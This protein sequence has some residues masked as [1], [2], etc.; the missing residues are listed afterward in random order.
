V[1]KN[2]DTT[3]QRAARITGAIFR[4]GEGRIGIVSSRLH[5]Y[6]VGFR[7]AHAELIHDDQLDMVT[8]SLY[9]RHGQS[10]DANIEK[11]HRRP[12]DEAKAN[13]LARPEERLLG[14][15]PEES[16]VCDLNCQACRAKGV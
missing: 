12:I 9:Y 7:T 11:S 10:G 3:R 1:R 5:D 16:G 13:A 4:L 14:G 6:V 2:L 15:P 8:V